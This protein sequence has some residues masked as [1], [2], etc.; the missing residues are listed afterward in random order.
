[1]ANTWQGEFPRENHALDGYQRTSPV[2]AFPPNG[3]GLHDVIGNVWEWTTDWYSP[4]HE[5]DAA[6][7]FCIPQNPRAGGMR[8]TT[9][10]SPTFAFHARS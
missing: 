7:P 3:Y 2:G 10:A 5:G 1:M 4:L 8:A 6:K 9:L